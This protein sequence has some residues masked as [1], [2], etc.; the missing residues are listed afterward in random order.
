MV[1]SIFLKRTLHLALQSD[2]TLMRECDAK[3]GMMWARCAAVG[4]P[5]KSNMQVCMDCTW[6]PLGRHVTMGLLA[7]CMLVTGAPVLRKLLVVPESKMALLVMVSMSIS[8][9]Q[10][11]VAAARA[12]GWVGVCHR[13]LVQPREAAQK[14]SMLNLSGERSLFER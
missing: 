2:T 10:R 12:Y 13:P 6:L 11:G 4:R 3:P 7:S 14:R 9:V 8:T 1:H 5:G